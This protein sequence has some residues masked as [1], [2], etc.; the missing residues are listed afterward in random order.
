MDR[1]AEA[2]DRIDREGKGYISH[3][4]LKM[5]LGKDYDR[6]TVN[7]MIEEGDFKKNDK[8]DYEELL[9]LMFEDPSKAADITGDVTES[10]RSLEGFK[11]L[12]S[13]ST[14]R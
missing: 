6:E 11:D 4:D 9:K 14:S 1:L 13:K 5:V 12:V 10:L 2:F 8:I 3:D 7:R